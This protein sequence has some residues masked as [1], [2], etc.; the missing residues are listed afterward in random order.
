MKSYNFNSDDPIDSHPV[1]PFDIDRIEV[2]AR[3][4]RLREQY[5]QVCLDIQQFEIDMAEQ[6][7]DSVAET[8][9]RL[10]DS[11]REALEEVLDDL[12]ESPTVLTDGG[13]DV[14][15]PDPADVPSGDEVYARA[16]NLFG[17]YVRDIRDELNLTN[18]EADWLLDALCIDQME[19]IALTDPE[20]DEYVIHY[21][22]GADVLMLLSDREEFVVWLECAPTWRLGALG[23]NWMQEA[24]NRAYEALTGDDETAYLIDVYLYLGR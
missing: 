20:N 5:Q 9:F 8:E 4:D 7:W 16:K 18:E 19:T 24:H 6:E 15:T 23:M 10:L 1:D 11:Q 21:D 22:E 2:E 14:S 13:V 12:D 17:T 3:I